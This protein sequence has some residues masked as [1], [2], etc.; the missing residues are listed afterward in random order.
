MRIYVADLRRDSVSSYFGKRS[1]TPDFMFSV[2]WCAHLQSCP[3]KSHLIMVIRVI[4][5]LKGTINLGLQYPRTGQFTIT[6]YSNAGYADC[7]VDRKSTSGTCQFLGNYLV[8][9]SSKKQISVALSTVEA[10]Y[11][12]V[13]ACCAQIL[14]MKHTLLDYDLHFDHVKIFCDNSSTC[15]LYTSPS[16]R[17]S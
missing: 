15:L 3:K 8:S 4:R 5:Y 16:P 1:V 12:A 10:E 14:W 9:W 17:D 6:S 11:I 13:G 2:Y 7:K